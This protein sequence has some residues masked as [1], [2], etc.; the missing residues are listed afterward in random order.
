MNAV[1][2]AALF[3]FLGVSIGA[4]GAHKL[5]PILLANGQLAN[6]ETG[7]HYHLI[8]AVVMLAVALALPAGAR[9]TPTLWLF[10][11]GITIF[12]G[13]LYVLALTNITKLGMITPIGGLCL[14]AGWV[15]LAIRGLK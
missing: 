4:F 9:P 1:R 7:A 6:F 15:M 11:A 3:G 13:S 10:T 2:L 14:L 5:K 8:H 12:S